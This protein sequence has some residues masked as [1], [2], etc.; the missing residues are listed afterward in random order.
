[1]EGL[2]ISLGDALPTTPTNGSIVIIDTGNGIF[3]TEV[4]FVGKWQI[5][6]RISLI[7]VQHKQ[8]ILITSEAS[9]KASLLVQEKLEKEEC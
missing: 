1:M 3:G 8:E 9:K 7:H 6:G 4:E 5:T 2:I